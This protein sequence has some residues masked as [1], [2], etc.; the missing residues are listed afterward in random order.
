MIVFQLTI[1]GN[2]DF[3]DSAVEAIRLKTDVQLD[4]ARRGDLGQ[5]M[6]NWNIAK[7]MSSLVTREEYPQAVNQFRIL[8]PGAG[9]GSLS[10]ALVL[11]LCSNERKFDALEVTAF[12]IDQTMRSG[13]AET[14]ALLESNGF[15]HH[16]IIESDFIE[17]AVEL[18]HPSIKV[19]EGKSVNYDFVILNPPYKK[20]SSS[21]L[22]R[23]LLR[24]VGIE[25]TNLYTAFWQ[26]SILLAKPGAQVCAIVPRSF[27][28]GTY[29]SGFRKFLKSSCDIHHIHVFDSRKEA[30]SQNDVLQENVI[31]HCIKKS[32]QSTKTAPKIV[33]SRSADDSFLDLTSIALEASQVWDCS[34]DNF[35]FIPTTNQSLGIIESIRSLPNSLGDLGLKV[36]TGPVVQFRLRPSLSFESGAPMIY[37]SN[38]KNGVVIHNPYAKKS[39]PF[40]RVDDVSRKWLVENSC[41][42]VVRRFSSKEEKRRIVCAVHNPG[43]VAEPIHEFLGIDNKLNYFYSPSS[44]LSAE[45][46]HGLFVFLSSS[47]VDS[48]YRLVS[49]HTQVNSGDLRSLRYPS[50]SMLRSVGSS[51]MKNFSNRQESIDSYAFQY[52]NG[53]RSSNGRAGVSFN[54]CPNIDEDLPLIGKVA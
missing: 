1:P 8:D 36:S 18:L 10:A 49:G 53:L 41:Y 31:F 14:G 37:C 3:V 6:T 16:H 33:V 24:K 34:K 26:L 15:C 38:M 23:Q 42:L 30:F 7:F 46:A 35:I 45:V 43:L 29:F 48:Y 39:P 47:F 17:A 52:F 51:F 20:I 22:H 28:N 54:S 5:F 44:R 19:S 13:L 25:A 12:E 32:S 4:E 9:V 2:V 11:H 27:C 50:L 40:I 21:S